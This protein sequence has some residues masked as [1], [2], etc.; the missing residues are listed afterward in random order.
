MRFHFINLTATARALLEQEGTFKA[1]YPNQSD[2]EGY[3]KD[4]AAKLFKLNCGAIS[5]PTALTAERM[6]MALWRNAGVTFAPL[7][8]A[9]DVSGEERGD[10]LQIPGLDIVEVT[11]W[12][13]LS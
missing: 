5:G 11:M 1:K 9:P 3:L 2:A 10:P 6:H 13:A 12:V 7:G 4:Q 8:R